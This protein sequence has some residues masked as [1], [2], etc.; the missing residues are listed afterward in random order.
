MVI[1]FNKPWGV[2]S[3]FTDAGNLE[4]DAATLSVF[5]DVPNV[6]A[7][8]RLDKDSEGLAGSDR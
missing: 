3:Q 5:I 8:G 6:Y 4:S 2:L 7:A 1:L